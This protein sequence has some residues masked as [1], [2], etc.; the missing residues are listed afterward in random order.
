MRHPRASSY[1]E[2]LQS[3]ASEMTVS[4]D[5][6]ASNSLA[7]LQ[8]SVARQ[9]M[10]C[11]EMLAFMRGAGQDGSQAVLTGLDE[12]MQQQMNAAIRALQIKSAEFAALLKHSGRSLDLL[13]SLHKSCSGQLPN[14]S[15]PPLT[16]QTWS[17]EA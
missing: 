8:E 9:Q 13:D 1:V 4:M 3:L 6:I 5:A 10:L 7:T 17:C 14:S 11:G 2:H 12:L 16:R 15:E